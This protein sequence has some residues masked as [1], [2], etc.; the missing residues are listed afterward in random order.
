MGDVI[1]HSFRYRAGFQAYIALPWYHAAPAPVAGMSKDG[2]TPPAP[3]PAPAPG[4]PWV[5]VGLW[6]NWQ[7]T[8]AGSAIGG[9]TGIGLGAG[10]NVV[11]AHE[12]IVSK[13]I[14][15]HTHTAD[16][17][18]RPAFWITDNIALQGQFAGLWEENPG[19]NGVGFP[20]FGNKSGWMGVFDFGPV[21][22]PKGGYYTRPELRFFA[23]YAIWSDS[24]KGLSTPVG[25]FSTPFMA[26]YNGNTNHGWLFGTQV[27]WYF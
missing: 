19:A 3:A 25:E 14:S 20:G 9:N 21:I 18:M 16:F 4:L 24:L 27:E 5:S 12:A 11:N 2:K 17:G 1:D 22:K 13:V 7:E 15:G 23:T 26:P 6:A 10:G 8:Y